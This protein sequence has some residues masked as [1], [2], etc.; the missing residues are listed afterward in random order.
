[1]SATLQ[2]D[3]DKQKFF[4][5]V[6]KALNDHNIDGF[7]ALESHLLERLQISSDEELA[8]LKEAV[9]TVFEKVQ[10]ALEKNL[11]RWE[12]YCKT[13]CFYV[14]EIVETV[15]AEEKEEETP[16]P[17][18][19]DIAR[20][21]ELDNELDLLRSRIL[22][23]RRETSKLNRE[24]QTLE[25]WLSLKRAKIDAVNEAASSVDKTKLSI[26]QAAEISE[27]AS[28]MH[29]QMKKAEDETFAKEMDT[30]SKAAFA[31]LLDE[32]F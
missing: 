28:K 16:Q 4:V 2:G 17:D 27:A 26:M 8:Q 7:D 1:M 29:E 23:V 18:P 6:A 10:M 9:D 21:A 24:R 14:P 13:N 11:L 22:S 20:E 31:K 3:F 12:K 5:E 25:T 32:I 19:V 30:K 15:Q